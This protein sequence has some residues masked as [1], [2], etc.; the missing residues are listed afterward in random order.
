MKLHVAS[1]AVALIA[2]LAIGQSLV[3]NTAGVVPPITNP[4][5]APCSTAPEPYYFAISGTVTGQ[6]NPNQ[7]L[8]LL[9]KPVLLNGGPIFGC[10]WIK[11]CYTTTPGAGGAITLVG[12]MGTNNQPRSWF[13]GAQAEVMFAVLPAG[14][15]VCVRDPFAI[16]IATSNITRVNLDPTI[17]NLFDFQIPCRGSAMN[18]TGTPTPGQSITYTLP[19]A[20]AVG[21]G[22]LDPNGFLIF[23][24]QAYFSASIPVV[25][26]NTDASGVLMLPIPN[27]PGIVGADLS[28]QGLIA[29]SGGLDLTQPTLVQ[30]R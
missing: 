5:I 17:P 16:A 12:Q 7:E 15:P 10:E 1:F 22:F 9:V 19:Q 3:V 29:V 24:C 30:I 23:G 18:V 13:S 4:N 11:Q 14:A 27:V 25:V 26:I 20:G 28:S 6:I 2:P 21:F 8:R